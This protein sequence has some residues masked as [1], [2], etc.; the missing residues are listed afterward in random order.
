MGDLMRLNVIIV[1]ERFLNKNLDVEVSWSMGR[2]G[3]ATH[4]LLIRI[5]RTSD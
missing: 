5:F 3:V 1:F 2:P 4:V